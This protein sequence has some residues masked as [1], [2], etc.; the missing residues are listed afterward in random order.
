MLKSISGKTNTSTGVLCVQSF[1]SVWAVMLLGGLSTRS[2]LPPVLF[3]AFLYFFGFAKAQKSG[4][5]SIYSLRISVMTPVLAGVFSLL[6][7]AAEHG[8][9]TA[10]LENR[11]FQA[12]LLLAGSLGVFFLFYHFLLLL[13]AALADYRLEKEYAPIRFLPLMGFLGCLLCWLPYFLYEYPAVMT[14]DSINQFEQVLGMVPYSNHHPWVHTM[15]LKGLYSFG[16]LFTND[17]NAALAF[18]T[19]FQMCFMA[20]C[21]AWLISTLQ[22]FQAG[23]LPCLLVLAFYALV[24]YH[25]VF[26]VTI[27]KDIPFSGSILLFTTALLRL[28]LLFPKNRRSINRE[29]NRTLSV[30]SAVTAYL[31]SGILI[32]LLRSNGWYAFLLSLPFLLFAFRH[33]LKT[34][35]PV[36]L[37]ILATALLVKIPVMDAFRVA[38]PDF[39]ESISIP[40]QQ[41]A[42][43]IC[44]DKGLTPEQWD[45][46][47]KVIDTTYIQELYSPGFADNMKELVRAGHPE[48]LTAHKD[49]YFRLWLSLGLR[50]PAVYLQA[51]AD[52]TMGYWYPDTAYAV[53]NIDGIIQNAT[54]AASR[55][56]LRGPFV[57]KTKEILLKLSDILP[58]YGL[59]T[60]MGAMFWLFLCCFTVTVIKEQSERYILFLPGFAVLLT[61]FAATPVSS[62]F[63]YAYPLAY[64]LP[65]YV[66]LPFLQDF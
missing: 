38:Q 34:M 33:C 23:N 66:L 59:L 26:A 13:F 3:A 2:I 41:V 28:L 15:I 37:A 18:Y 51:Y 17:V 62:E 39:V 21:V 27:W 5:L 31:F 24:P 61:L 35:L 49:E 29:R 45:S 6:T 12:I 10:G 58:L 19:L 16:R 43:V 54:G 11:L 55:P 60:S 46:V 20:F 47:Y 7:L 4:T 53:G 50:Y 22:H 1:F 25:G 52:Q 63:R 42:R 14:P 30:L 36:H 65:L 8:K 48:Y 32:C 57:V 44:E 40:L 56:L 64:T 9:F